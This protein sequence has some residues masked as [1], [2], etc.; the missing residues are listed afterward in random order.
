MDKVKLGGDG[1]M[2]SF[3]VD[4]GLEEGGIYQFLGKAHSG[5]TSVMVEFASQVQQKPSQNKI[6]WIDAELSFNSLWAEAKG[7]DCTSVSDGGTLNLIQPRF[8]EEAFD[9]IFKAIETGEYGLVVLDADTSLASYHRWGDIDSPNP[10]LVLFSQALPRLK[11][12][13]ERS[14]TVMCWVSELR[15]SMSMEGG[16]K[17]TGGLLIRELSKHRFEV[18]VLSDEDRKELGFENGSV[19]IKVSTI[20][21]DGTDDE[22][23]FYVLSQALNYASYLPRLNTPLPGLQKVFGGHPIKG[24]IYQFQGQESTGN[25]A[26]ALYLA[27]CTHKQPKQ[28]KVLWV[29]MRGGFEKGLADA[30]VD[31][32]EDN[33]RIVQPSGTE[34]AFDAMVSSAKTGEF[35]MIVV[36]SGVCDQLAQA[37]NNHYG[38]LSYQLRITNTIVCWISQDLWGSESPTQSFKNNT[39]RFGS[40][41][42]FQ[43]TQSKVLM[44]EGDMSKA[45]GILIK[46][47]NLKNKTGVPF[48][49]TEIY[50]DFAK[51]FDVDGSYVEAIIDL[52]IIPLAGAWYKDPERGISVQGSAKLK[53]WLLDP[54]N[55]EVFEDLKQKVTEAYAQEN[56]EDRE[57]AFLANGDGG[58]EE[59]EVLNPDEE[60]RLIL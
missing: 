21:K 23:P 53:D 1:I 39:I 46:L 14:G 13:I 34:A 16:Y 59:V 56:D 32:S 47:K 50:L 60:P 17:P 40:S 10:L 52:K 28:N 19:V 2:R 3:K 38:R 57:R 49:E 31:T 43:T 4:Y 44:V 35:G 24:R 48:R 27:D 12:A 20:T 7:L 42:R 22:L 26:V 8:A 45:K 41:A 18:S 54:V 5:R 9:V 6:L 29:D 37:L 33:F 30:L 36:D 58:L 11:E 15:S 51:G 55:K 25:V